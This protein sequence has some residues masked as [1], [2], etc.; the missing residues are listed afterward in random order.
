[1]LDIPVQGTG[2]PR[3]VVKSWDDDSA[4]I[5]NGYF[6]NTQGIKEKECYR[7]VE[8]NMSKLDVT[9]KGCLGSTMW[10]NY[11]PHV[12]RE[13]LRSGHFD[14]VPEINGTKNTYYSGS[15]FNFETVFHTMS[16]SQWIVEEYF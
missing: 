3:D 4:A 10:I 12:S 11:F 6:D 8:E 1:M 15:L 5:F 13:A 14:K 7:F 16:V 9:V 2:H